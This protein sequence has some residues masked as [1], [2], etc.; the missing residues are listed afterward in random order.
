M[1]DQYEISQDTL[2][3]YY[4]AEMGAT[5]PPPPPPPSAVPADFPKGLKY[6]PSQEQIDFWKAMRDLAKEGE[7]S[8]QL[9]AV[10]GSGKTTTIVDGIAN[11]PQGTVVLAFAKKIATELQKRLPGGYQA[12]TFNAYWWKFLRGRLPNGAK[13]NAY[14]TY[15]IVDKLPNGD[16][17]QESRYAIQ[18]V[19]GLCKSY[20]LGILTPLATET[21]EELIYLH[22][23]DDEFLSE[24]ELASWALAV[25]KRNERDLKL[26]DFDDQLYVSLKFITERGWK[27]D[28][29]PM[30]LVDEY[31][32]INPV[33]AALLGH[34]SKRIVGVGDPRQA[35][36]AFRGAGENSMETLK[37][38]FGA[39]EYPLSVSW[40]C[41]RT[42]VE[43]AQEINPLIKPAPNAQAG[44]IKEIGA[45]DV[46]AHLRPDSLVVCRNNFPLVGIALKLLR[47]RKPFCMSGKFPAKLM[48][49]V[50]GSKAANIPEFRAYLIDWWD[51]RSKEL[52]QKS[53]FGTLAAEEDKF[54]SLFSLQ[55]ECPTMNDLYGKLDYLLNSKGGVKLYTVHGAKGLESDHVVLL[56][57]E[58]IPSKYATTGAALRQENNLK[59][60][61][62]T[63]SKHTLVIAEG[64]KE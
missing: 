12:D 6:I 63:R 50:K 18:Q 20:G 58:L 19:V 44:V 26:M 40:R 54:E 41:P 36:F 14:K 15:Q 2:N 22:Q 29:L 13:I 10:A 46:L 49:F 5:P 64:E 9:N 11:T 39:T 62:L 3:D 27:A 43:L 38:Q 17:V 57:P 56:R 33:Q 8:V 59:Y 61:A 23:I 16:T 21:I 47:D 35:I 7:G 32:D 42:H 51:K 30:V 28:V 34:M 52:E 37:E 60:V 31:Q 25:M 55:A 1:S 53:Q 4:A 45:R 24:G 48:K